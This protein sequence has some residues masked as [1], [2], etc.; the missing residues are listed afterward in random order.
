MGSSG[1]GKSSLLK[2]ING[3]YPFEGELLINDRRLSDVSGEEWRRDMGF[4]L[5]HSALFPHWTVERNISL[6]PRLKK[7]SKKDI[8]F[9][10]EEVL[11]LV[12]LPYRDFARRLPSQ[13]S[14]GQQ[15]RVSIGRALA[16]DPAVV[17]FDEPFSA[18]DP[19]TR[20]SLQEEVLALKK[21]LNKTFVFV[22]HDIGEAFML[23]D[24]IAVMQGGSIIQKGSPQEI[25]KSPA[26]EY[27]KS[28]IYEAHS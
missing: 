20:K 16:A 25:K 26:N 4:V 15:Q 24:E 13:L 27:V 3:L 9:R 2:T 23:G 11:D 28:L 12:R 8:S 7:W 14:G 22:T 18:L 1:S 6:V 10:V 19:I 5:Q 17:L 21:E